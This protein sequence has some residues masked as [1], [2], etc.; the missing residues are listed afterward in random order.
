M[1]KKVELN[2]LPE[3]EEKPDGAFFSEGTEEELAE[4]IKMEDQGWKGF[5]NKVKNI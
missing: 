5:I 1:K 4:F 3:V 2:E